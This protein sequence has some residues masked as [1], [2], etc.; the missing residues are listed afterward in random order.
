MGTGA[1]RSLVAAVR[2]DR[3]GL[4]VGAERIVRGAGMVAAFGGVRFTEYRRG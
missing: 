4:V 3:R 1:L 2:L